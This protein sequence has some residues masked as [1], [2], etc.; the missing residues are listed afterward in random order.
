MNSSEATKDSWDQVIDGTGETGSLIEAD[1]LIMYGVAFFLDM[2]GYFCLLLT[3]TVALAPVAVVIQG[4]VAIVGKIIFTLWIVLVRGHKPS[5]SPVAVIKKGYSAAKRGVRYIQSHR[6]KEAKK[7]DSKKD[8]SSTEQSFQPTETS[9]TSSTEQSFQPTETSH[10]GDRPADA[11][12]VEKASSGKAVE[13]P[14]GKT[15]SVLV[16]W[17]KRVFIPWLI[18]STPFIGKFMPTLVLSVYFED[19]YG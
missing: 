15:T 4:I 9:H 10:T 14:S 1:I 8:T 11:T 3:M 7:E 2:I 12:S 19:K 18:E 17:I 5:F 13:A 16:K 6:N